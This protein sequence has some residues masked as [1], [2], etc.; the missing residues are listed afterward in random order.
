MRIRLLLVFIVNAFAFLPARALGTGVVLMVNMNYSSQELAAVKDIAAARGQRVEVVPPES[1]IPE[2]ENLFRQR[3]SLQTQ[4]Q[5]QFPQQ[6]PLVLKSALAGIFREGSA[7]N[8]DPAVA[9]FVGA[10]RANSFKAMA[11]HVASEEKANGEIFDQL[12][13]KAGEL[14]ARGDTVDSMILSSHSDGSNLTGETA[15]RLSSNDLYKLKQMEPAL[16]DS[17]RHVLL[18]G[19]YTMTKPNHHSWRYDIFPRASLLAGFGDKAPSRFDN[20][21]ANFIRQVLGKAQSLDQQMAASGRALD[22]AA[23]A[24]AFRS[25]DAVTTGAHPGVIDYCYSMVEGQP[26]AWSHDCNQQWKD[27]YQ[28][29]AMMKPYWDLT[30][31]KEDPPTEAGG[32]LRVFYNMLQEACPAKDTPSERDD[33]KNS[34][35]MRVTYRE[36][37]IRLLFW[38]NVQ[39]NFGTYLS[40]EISTMNT[41]LRVYGIGPMPNLN[42]TVS[43]VAFVK[44]YNQIDNA[45]KARDPAF[46]RQFEALYDP[47]LLL[48]GE[49]S[50][51]AG[52]KLDVDSTLDR[53][54]I[55][56]NWIE[57]VTVKKRG[58]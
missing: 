35:T 6:N 40:A 39:Q 17:A 24:Q 9:Q 10:Q 16:F 2:V 52:E 43:R 46:A 3:D 54:A 11:D 41:R 50:V 5:R 49:D 7:W 48:Q 38:W 4:L 47:L 30:S 42:G 18:L 51:A 21:S 1:M 37:A 36:N 29:K 13:R 44:A 57:G 45:V 15:N 25:L 14:R 53:G 20:T 12:K 32:D 27:L 22:P 26:G 28:K 34:E 8:G 23:L 58:T 55:P 33:W 31:P 56:F 19:C